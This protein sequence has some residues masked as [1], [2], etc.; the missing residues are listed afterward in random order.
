MDLTERESEVVAEV[1]KGQTNAECAEALFICEQTIKF[2]LTNVY[3]K[4]KIRS[5]GEL[6]LKYHQEATSEQS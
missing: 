6:I 4:L 5:R 3:R 2:H 1:L